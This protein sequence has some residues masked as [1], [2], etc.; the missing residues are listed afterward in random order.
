MRARVCPEPPSAGPVASAAQHLPEAHPP[1]TGAWSLLQLVSNSQRL[2]VLTAGAG[3]SRAR[4]PAGDFVLLLVQG[5]SSSH[6]WLTRF[7]S[8][9]KLVK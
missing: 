8:R 2:A 4:S 5:A 9:A 1:S 3:E 7:S 6:A